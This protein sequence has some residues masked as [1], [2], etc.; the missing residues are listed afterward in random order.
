MSLHAD[1]PTTPMK[2]QSESFF[3]RQMRKRLWL[4]ICVMDLQASSAHG[5]EPLIPVTEVSSAL[6]GLRHLDDADF[7]EQTTDEIPEREDLTCATFAFVTYHAQ[8][9]GRLLS[10]AG[11]QQ[12]REDVELP[13]SG[14]GSV[15]SHSSSVSSL[16]APERGSP[17]SS[18]PLTDRGSRE[19]TSAA[20]DRKA[21]ELIRFCDPEASRQAWFTWHSTQTLVASTRLA[22]LRPLPSTF[23]GH[24]RDNDME[25]QLSFRVLEKVRL[26]HADSRCDGLRW[27]IPF[28][29]HALAVAIAGCYVCADEKMLRERWPLVEQ[30]WQLQKTQAGCGGGG[31]SCCSTALASP[32]ERLVRKTRE[33]LGRMVLVGG[34]GGNKNAILAN[35]GNPLSCKIVPPDRFSSAALQQNTLPTPPLTTSSVAS[36]NYFMTPAT[37][38][39]AGVVR[40]PSRMDGGAAA[41]AAAPSFS[42]SD[43]HQHHQPQQRLS[44]HRAG[45]GSLGGGGGHQSALDATVLHHRNF[46]LDSFPIQEMED[47]SSDQSQ[48][49][50]LFDGIDLQDEDMVTMFAL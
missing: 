13:L 48:Q 49:D 27:Y 31:G 28:P 25:L 47:D 29:W 10:Y 18:F 23:T 20:F 45:S 12:Q 11:Q 44:Y 21:F 43:H 14:G 6:K 17:P 42:S 24:E 26:M 46:T 50:S 22:A 5:S 2:Y 15:R 38:G 35:G 33:R 32:L 39:G 3:D 4:T 40:A 8:V 37:P 7:D 30:V 1:A 41:A 34:G 36:A 16:Y 9:S 19:R